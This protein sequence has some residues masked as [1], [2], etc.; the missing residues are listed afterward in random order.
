[1][2]IK[3]KTFFSLVFITVFALFVNPCFAMSDE[4]LELYNQIVSKNNILDKHIQDINDSAKQIDKFKQEAQNI[5]RNYKKT[6]QTDINVIINKSTNDFKELRLKE[7]K[8]I[9]SLPVVQAEKEFDDVIILVKEFLPKLQ[10]EEFIIDEDYT[11]YVIAN[12]LT[13]VSQTLQK[14]AGYN[15]KIYSLKL[16]LIQQQ[17]LQQLEERDIT[18]AQIDYL[19]NKEAVQKAKIAGINAQLNQLEE[20]AENNKKALESAKGQ[21]Q[22][23]AND[24]KKLKKYCWIPFY[25]FYWACKDI[26]NEVNKKY[27]HASAR[28]EQYA[29]Q[30]EKCQNEKKD[31]DKELSKLNNDIQKVQNVINECNN[32]LSSYTAQI[33]SLTQIKSKYSDMIVEIGKLINAF[34]YNSNSVNSILEIINSITYKK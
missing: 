5:T 1:M 33:N 28:A 3:N 12:K 27:E 30:L 19:K 11:D 18:I 26:D 14:A 25:G 16:A 13:I 9:D 6:Q 34:E 21:M 15:E 23:V 31:L 2:V 8:C 29:R 7:Q 17:K 20:D 22:Q 10:Q 24:R 32:S 4:T